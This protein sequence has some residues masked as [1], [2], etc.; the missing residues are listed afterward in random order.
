MAITTLQS[1]VRLKVALA[2]LLLYQ[3][4]RALCVH[5]AALATLWELHVDVRLGVEICLSP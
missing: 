2:S 3:D 5:A 1:A 4:D